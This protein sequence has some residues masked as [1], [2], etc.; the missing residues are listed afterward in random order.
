MEQIIRGDHEVYL[1]STRTT[2]SIEMWWP[3]ALLFVPLI[4]LPTVPNFPP[5]AYT[6][7]TFPTITFSLITRGRLYEAWIA[8]PA[9]KS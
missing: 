7:L 6:A 9:N 8:Y 2:T 3:A 4:C 5:M 1:I